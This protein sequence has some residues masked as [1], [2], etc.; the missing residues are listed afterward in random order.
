MR[1]NDSPVEMV[2]SDRYSARIA[3]DDWPIIGA[4]VTVLGPTSRTGPWSGTVTAISR[5]KRLDLTYM[6]KSGAERSLVSY[7][8]RSA[9]LDVGGVVPVEGMRATW[10]ATVLASTPATRVDVEF[11]LQ[12][13]EVRHR[14]FFADIDVNGYYEELPQGGAA[15]YEFR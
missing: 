6:L 1:L 13:G 14:P 2:S 5:A 15:F 7:E 3:P 9:A 11:T 12:S 10:Q 8:E 4:A